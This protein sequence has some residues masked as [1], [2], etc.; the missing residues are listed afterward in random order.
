[1]IA[2]TI[3]GMTLSVVWEVIFLI[4]FI[5]I[6]LW[7]ASIAHKKGYSFIGFYILSIFFWWITLF[8][9]LVLKDKNEKID[10]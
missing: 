9:V 2:T 6:A 10:R 7:P 1:L 5:L 4:F 8:V 3:L